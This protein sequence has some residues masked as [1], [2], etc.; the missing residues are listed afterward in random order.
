MGFEQGGSRGVRG[1]DD[2]DPKE[3]EA[4]GTMRAW[5]RMGL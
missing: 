1:G 4:R 5:L 2:W 3:G